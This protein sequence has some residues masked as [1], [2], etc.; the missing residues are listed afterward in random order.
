MCGALWA[1]LQRVLLLSALPSPFSVSPPLP[2]LLPLPAG[3]EDGL[4]ARCSTSYAEQYLDV[5]LA[6][7]G[8]V[9]RL[10][11]S[12]FTPAALVRGLRGGRCHMPF[13]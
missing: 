9:N 5:T 12:P 1:A 13:A 2:S 4:L 8:P 10:R 6:H 3:T 11:F 7:A